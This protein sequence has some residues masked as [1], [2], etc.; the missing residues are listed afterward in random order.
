[1]HLFKTTKPQDP[2]YE[3]IH[4]LECLREQITDH[5]AEQVRIAV[6]SGPAEGIAKG[7]DV[8]GGEGSGLRHIAAPSPEGRKMIKAQRKQSAKD[9]ALNA[10]GLEAQAAGVRT[11]RVKA[12][13]KAQGSG[14]AKSSPPHGTCFEYFGSMGN[15]L[16]GTQEQYAS[17]SM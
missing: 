11:P 14:G 7:T 10:A 12:E 6:R 3:R 17:G 15:A 8:P 13:A 9:K 2:T 1:M 16:L 5:E 4:S